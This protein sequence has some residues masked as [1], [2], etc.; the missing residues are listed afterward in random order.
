MSNPNLKYFGYYHAAVAGISDIN[1]GVADFKKSMDVCADHCN[2]VMIQIGDFD[3]NKDLMDYAIAKG[4]KIILVSNHIYT[5]GPDYKP[6][7][8]QITKCPCV[9]LVEGDN[10]LK[11]YIIANS[12]HFF[13]IYFLDEPFLTQ[14]LLDPQINGDHW[15]CAD[16][17]NQLYAKL[18][19]Y[20]GAIPQMAPF[21]YQTLA[22]LNSDSA[23]NK[24]KRLINSLRFEYASVSGAYLRDGFT[25]ANAVPDFHTQLRKMW[26]DEATPGFNNRRRLFVTG[27]AYHDPASDANFEQKLIQ[28]SDELFDLCKND[29]HVIAYI[30]FLF[31]GTVGVETLPSLLDKFKKIGK[32]IIG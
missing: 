18:Q 27:D 17:I 24:N 13:G 26:I 14:N 8:Y 4:L 9:N 32:E 16:M 6:K 11:D 19:Y 21:S 23:A 30:P 3:T 15:L 12:D 5:I 31:P 20:F 1:R 10:R 2:L 29:D 7:L 22:A 25:K 28:R